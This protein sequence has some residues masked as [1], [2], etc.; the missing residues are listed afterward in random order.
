MEIFKQFTF[1]SAHHLPHVPEGHKCK[2][3]HGHTY[4][5]TLYFEGPLHPQLGWV[6]DF[7]VIKKVV[8]PV[9]E[10][11]DHKNLNEIDGL[12]NPTCEI[13]GVWIWDRVKPM[14]PSLSRLELNETPTSGVVYRGI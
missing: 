1:D 3:V 13:I 9:I 5:L 4:R 12:E 10:T 8:K 2:N 11:L 7:A 6:E 14:I